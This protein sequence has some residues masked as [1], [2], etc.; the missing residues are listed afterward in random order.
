MKQTR[1]ITRRA[2][3]VATVRPV[4]AAL[5]FLCALLATSASAQNPTLHLQTTTN[6]SLEFIPGNQYLLGNSAQPL[7][8]NGMNNKP[9]VLALGRIHLQ[10]IPDFFAPLTSTLSTVYCTQSEVNAV[11]Q[12]TCPTL[13]TYFHASDARRTTT[14]DYVVCGSVMHTS[15][16]SNCGGQSYED[17]FIL[18]TNSQ[19]NVIW[20]KRYRPQ[21]TGN[22]VL[23]FNTIIEDA[24]TGNLIVGGERISSDAFVM[25]TTATGNVLWEHNITATMVTQAQYYTSLPSTFT[26]I[27]AYTS[28][29]IPRQGYV[30]TGP[31]QKYVQYSNYG[32]NYGGGMLLVVD[33]TGMIYTN[34][35]MTEELNQSTGFMRTQGV[36]DAFDNDV[37]LVGAAGGTYCGQHDELDLLL[38]KLDPI[39]L[40]T[41]TFMKVYEHG[42]GGSCGGGTCSIGVSSSGT[43]VTV[44]Q[45]RGDIFVGGYEADA[46]NAGTGAVYMQTSNIGVHNRYVPLN[47]LHGT[48][49]S[50]ITYN[51]INR[52]PA[53]SGLVGNQ[54]SFLIKDNT[55]SDCDQDTDPLEKDL[56]LQYV[57]NTESPLPID[58]I[59]ED[60]V[61]FVLPDTLLH[62]CGYA[63]RNAPTAIQ[64]TVRSK[65]LV[66][67]PNPAMEYV[68]IQLPLAVKDGTASVYDVQGRLVKSQSFT[69]ANQLVRMNISGLTPGMYSVNVLSQGKV[70]RATFVKE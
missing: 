28:P 67:A 64:T 57:D 16:F 15:E 21:Q 3:S 40:G 63:N 23:R 39:N 5:L 10:V 18:R 34:V 37:V 59:Q 19:G 51:S 50:A 68:N 8:I 42:S 54:P 20:Y 49:T 61:R 32:A 33:A 48:S 17:A 36:A 27:A 55:N 47:A 24:S 66:M 7:T 65:G 60:L 31:A 45:R 58:E 2:L 26:K 38:L 11:L 4:Q 46:Y 41:P 9:G 13:S 52:Y 44:G 69:S 29:N 56:D 14:G 25:G 35:L 30:L 53:Y 43:T 6:S 1:L 22:G 70:T 12:A 62:D